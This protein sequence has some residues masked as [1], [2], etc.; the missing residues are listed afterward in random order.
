MPTS[1][2]IT[3]VSD[4]ARWVAIYR[5]ME[6][7]RPDALFHD[8]YARRLAGERGEQILRTLPN[9]RTWAW[10]MVVRTAVMDELILRAVARD[11]VHTVVNLAAG[12]D[13]RPYRLSLPAGL[14]WI[15]VD[16]ADV[17]AYK[18]EQLASEKPRCQLE[19]VAVDLT[20]GDGRRELFRDAVSGGGGGT[21]VV[22]EGLL[23]Y[24]APA[25]VATLADDLQA[26]GFAWWLIDLASPQLLKMLSK[27]WGRKL[28]EGNAP[29]RFAPPESTQF[30]APH[31]WA[32]AEYRSMWEESVRLKRTMPMAWLWGL[33]GKFYSK[34]KREEFRRFSGIVLLQRT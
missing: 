31:G 8:S 23:V 3:H 33:I 5:A 21:L 29:F 19:R 11:G 25:E 13:T 10:P 15:E 18:E 22:A 32:E 26:A 9:A 20:D 30:F 24:L 27:T 6:S 17:L 14:R 2:P 16:F 12:L 28:E 4:T 1:N 34:K 7:E